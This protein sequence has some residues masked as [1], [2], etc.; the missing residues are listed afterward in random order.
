MTV[1]RIKSSLHRRPESSNLFYRKVIPAE[2]RPCFG[3]REIKYSFQTADPATARSR[4][5]QISACVERQIANA[6]AQLL[7]TE[8]ITDLQL[9]KLADEWYSLARSGAD[10]GDP[11]SPLSLHQLPGGP[12]KSPSFLNLDSCPQ[13]N[14]L[15]KLEKALGMDARSLLL[16]HGIA[17]N[18]KSAKYHNLLVLLAEKAL[19]IEGRDPVESHL[20]S[21][22]VGNTETPTLK[23]IWKRFEAL[24]SASDNPK[25]RGKVATYRS[26]FLKLIQHAGDIRLSML[27]REHALTF[28]DA[29]REL[30]DTTIPNFEQRSGLKPKEFR[31]LSLDRQRDIASEENLPV[32]TASGVKAALKRVAAVLAFADQELQT[33]YNV[34]NPMP[35]VPNSQTQLRGEAF[36][37]TKEEIER[38]LTSDDILRA[39]SVDETWCML[40][41]YLTGARLGEVA[42]MVGEDLVKDDQ[43]EA[44]SIR[45]DHSRGRTVKNYSS[46]RKVPIH[47]FLKDLGFIEYATKPAKEPLFTS[48]WDTTGNKANRF[49][50]KLK[51]LGQ[52]Q[53]IRSTVR[54]AHGFRH[55]VIGLWREAEKRQ[56]LQDAYLGHANRSQQSDYSNF[57]SLAKTASTVWPPI[58]DVDKLRKYLSRQ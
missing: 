42:P 58:P 13:A 43:T 33:K 5:H 24:Y 56:D 4:Y 11:I 9:Q 52:E 36:E 27:T 1:L 10:S 32:R 29:L 44:L 22:T 50:R 23:D 31:Q 54:P 14:S 18:H 48:L 3:K 21:A 26:D 15:D 38:L 2:L 55:H 7:G 12:R 49:S 30:P 57:S 25:D 45:E 28:R 47:P 17:L 20:L 39:L 41:L 35:M 8:E 37:Y 6:R 53:G 19:L 16:H 46:I 40:V 34:F 51:M